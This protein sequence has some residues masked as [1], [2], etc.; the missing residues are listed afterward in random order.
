[1]YANVVFDLPVTQKFTYAV[2]ASLEAAVVPGVRVFVPFGRRRMTGYVTDLPDSPPIDVALREIEDVFDTVPVVTS[3]ILALARWVSDYY[4]CGLG[5]A[6]KAALPAGMKIESHKTVALSPKAK[7][8]PHL[9]SLVRHPVQQKILH[10]LHA[11]PRVRVTT[12]S[13]TTGRIGVAYHL[14]KLLDNGLI[15]IE[16]ELFGRS[17]LE[18]TERFV[19]LRTAAGAVPENIPER[20]HR[21]RRIVAYLHEVGGSAKQVEVLQATQASS[22]TVKSLV[23]AGFLE[24]FERRI[25]RDYYGDLHVPPAPKLILNADQQAAV[26]SICA[27]VERRRNQVFLVHGVTGSGKTQVYIESIRFALSRGKTAIVLVPEISLTPQAVRR[28]RSEFQNAVAVMH[29]KM[30]QGERYDAWRRIREGRARVVVGPRSAIFAPVQNLGLIVVDEEQESSYKQT[31]NAPRYHA[32][33]V[34]VVRARFAGAVTVLGSATP[35]LESY[36][37]VL[38]GKYALLELKNR[39]DDIPLPK[40]TLLDIV[41]EKRIVAQKDDLIL[42]RLLLE[43]IREKLARQQQVII[44][45]NR[46][47]F[48][49]AVSCGDCGHVEMCP[50][51][52]ISLSYHRH[53][54]RMRC[55]YCELNQRAPKYCPKCGSMEIR[56]RG[57]GTQRV[58]DYLKNVLPQARIARMDLDT[59]RGKYAHDRILQ[60]F[61]AYKHDILIGTQMIAKGL[62]FPR[63]TL[64][65][66]I[67]ADTGLFLPDFRAA[68]KTFQLLT[69]VAGRAGRRGTQGEVI[70]QTFSPKHYCLQCAS[71][72]DFKGF[73]FTE[74]H[75]RRELKYP[76][77]GRLALLQLRHLDAAKVQAAAHKLAAFLREESGAF[78]LLGPAPAPLAKLQKY[79]RFQIILKNNRE[80]DPSA[81]RMRQA[82]RRAAGKFRA[83]ARYSRVTLTIDIDPLMIL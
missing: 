38:R 69:Q 23:A 32:R 26:D 16:N 56:Y 75:D 24:V 52:N 70:I 72:H 39:I 15:E 11:K 76:P 41:A 83:S 51:C 5:E 74:I 58:E 1:M 57:V 30:S 6:I 64:V 43:K 2:P 77:F 14:G 61:S 42:S 55:H 13:K 67:S 82:V 35:S 25:E 34:A 8:R 20:A 19:R 63:V 36:Q 27:A 45:Q 50:D 10:Y 71:R 18:K 44:L 40:V 7:A 47:G 59:T 3:E 31:D 54:L 12:L 53:G 46:R 33:D 60:D 78:D 73:F 4:L 17:H 29:S 68:E 80:S 9:D 28:F 49:P 48:S 66:V 65:G 37:N 22:A 21:Q 62:D 81:E 79:Y